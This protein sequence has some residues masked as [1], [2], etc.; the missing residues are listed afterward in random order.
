MAWNLARQYLNTKGSFWW[1]NYWGSFITTPGIVSYRLTPNGYNYFP[2]TRDCTTA[3]GTNNVTVVPNFSASFDDKFAIDQC[4]ANGPNPSV[5][6]TS[7]IAQPPIPALSKTRVSA[8]VWLYS[9]ATNPPGTITLTLTDGAGNQAVSTTV[10]NDGNL[11]R[12]GIS[13]YFGNQSTSVKLTVSWPNS[14][15]IV[16]L[17]GWQCEN[18]D[19]PSEYFDN[20]GTTTPQL[21]TVFADPLRVHSIAPYKYNETLTWSEVITN[22]GS[23]LF[24]DEHT[25]F[26]DQIYRYYSSAGGALNVQNVPNGTHLIYRAKKTAPVF[27]LGS[28]AAAT[29]GTGVVAANGQEVIDIPEPELWTVVLGVV[30]YLKASMYDIGANAEVGNAMKLFQNMVEELNLTSIEMPGWSYAD[31]VCA[32]MRR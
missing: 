5:S 18:N 16:Y 10:N 24:Q 6:K 30:A 29:P 21:R 27:T 2:A 19:W 15:G 28:V 32:G 11:Q 14:T 13:G 17:D 20:L 12:Y 3:T 9:D 31:I 1:D 4:V 8:S 26:P 7:L 23:E 25:S 22:V